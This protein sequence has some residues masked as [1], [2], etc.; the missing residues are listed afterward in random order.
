MHYS[1]TCRFPVIEDA[2]G[3]AVA[4]NGVRLRKIKMSY[5]KSDNA[6]SFRVR[7]QNG[8]P[9]NRTEI[10]RSAINVKNNDAVGRIVEDHTLRTE[11]EIWG[12]RSN[13]II[14]F[15]FTLFA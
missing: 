10:L 5:R 12:D 9:L 11:I 7:C 6:Y 4:S 3:E 8:T 14:G 1:L 15:I 2:I 13:Q